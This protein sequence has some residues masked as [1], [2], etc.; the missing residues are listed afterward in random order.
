MH[1]A[2][3]RLPTLDPTQRDRVSGLFEGLKQALLTNDET[4]VR[5]LE[6]RLIDLLFEL[7]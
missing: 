3:K 6:E 1:Q 2:E 5:Q 4:Q 7:E